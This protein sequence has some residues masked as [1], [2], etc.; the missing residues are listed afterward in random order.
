[1]RVRCG[2]CG[3][4]FLLSEEM[5]LEPIAMGTVCL[6]SDAMVY[7]DEETLKVEPGTLSSL[8]VLTF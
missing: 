8:S 7:C 5:S 2:D 4:A 3:K 1:M 6:S